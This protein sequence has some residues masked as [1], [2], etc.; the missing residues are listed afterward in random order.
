M[1]GIHPEVAGPVR[2]E[3]FIRVAECLYRRSQSG[4]YYALVKKGG[5]QFR[6]SCRVCKLRLKSAAGSRM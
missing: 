3:G 2:S 1:F 4:I 5:K 6:R